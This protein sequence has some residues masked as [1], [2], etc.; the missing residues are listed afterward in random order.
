[1]GDTIR[2]TLMGA[3]LTAAAVA[4]CVPDAAAQGGDGYLFREPRV[5][6]KIESGYAFQQARGDL[7]DDAIED[8]T[9]ERRDF[10]SPYFGGELAVRVS[11]RLDVALS[12][13]F[14]QTT[15]ESESRPYVVDGPGEIPILQTT[16]FRQIPLAV[17]TKLYPL[18]RGR[19]LG[20]FAWIPRTVAP[21][22]GGGIGLMNYRYEQSGEFVD[23]ET[24]DIYVDRFV[25]DK[26]GFLARAAAGV[27]VS[28]G[29]QFLFTAESRYTWASADVGGSFTRYDTIDLDGLQVIGGIGIRF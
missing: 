12:V 21:F 2:R 6:V 26:Q 15:I 18:A 1:M 11:E 14:Q 23:E 5:T 3:V 24:L 8:F 7:F 4:V 22:V 16:E 9:I 28:L 27:N 13:G 10:D 19:S 20:R 29:K 17:S 25:T